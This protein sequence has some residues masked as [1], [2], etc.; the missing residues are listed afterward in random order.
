[1]LHCKEAG[2]KRVTLS[3][4]AAIDAEVNPGT[5]PGTYVPTA[6]LNVSLPGRER[7]VANFVVDAAEQLCPYSNATRGNIEV[8]INLV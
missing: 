1:M 2:R 7:E 5:R 4:V 6:R 8:A 3:A